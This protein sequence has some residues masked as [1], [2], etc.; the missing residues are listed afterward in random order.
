M[1]CRQHVLQARCLA[2]KMSCRQDHLAHL[3]CLAGKMSCRQDHL[4]HLAHLACPAGNISTH[5]A[6]ILSVL[7]VLSVLPVLSV[8]SVLSVL[9]VLSVLLVGDVQRCIAVGGDVSSHQHDSWCHNPTVMLVTQS[10][11][12]LVSQSICQRR[13][14]C[15]MTLR[16]P[17]PRGGFLFTMFPDQEPGGRGPPMKNHPQN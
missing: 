4:A 8:L 1:S 6:G 3:E 15:V 2:G 7:S 10:P 13:M 16:N 9:P 17:P 5:L 12:L 14:D 11:V